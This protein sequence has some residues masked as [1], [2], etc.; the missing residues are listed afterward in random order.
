V[1]FDVLDEQETNHVAKFSAK[2]EYKVV[3]LANSF[4]YS[5]F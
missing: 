1:K 2:S 3:K 5:C 4:G